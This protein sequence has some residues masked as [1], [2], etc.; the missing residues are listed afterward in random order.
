M[1]TYKSVTVNR[2]TTIILD[3]VEQA[4]QLAKDC[5]AKY[6]EHGFHTAYDSQSKLDD[7]ISSIQKGDP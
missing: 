7:C 1:K 4:I 3:S 5:P 2:G 6:L